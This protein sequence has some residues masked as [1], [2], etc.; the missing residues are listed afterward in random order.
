MKPDETRVDFAT[1]VSKTTLKVSAC[2]LAILAGIALIAYA[3]YT[4]PTWVGCG[5][6]GLL[7]AYASHQNEKDKHFFA[8]LEGQLEERERHQKADWERHQKNAQSL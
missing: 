6:L 8:K 2:A 7:G 5:L 4:A 3:C 1:R